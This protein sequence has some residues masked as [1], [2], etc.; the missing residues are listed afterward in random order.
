MVG[1]QDSIVSYSKRLNF[2]GTKTKLKDNKQPGLLRG[3]G[4]DNDRYEIELDEKPHGERLNIDTYAV[5]GHSDRSG[6]TVDFLTSAEEAQCL[7]FACMA[8]EA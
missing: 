2:A 6:Q 5:L 7:R 8:L 3:K 4:N 1:K